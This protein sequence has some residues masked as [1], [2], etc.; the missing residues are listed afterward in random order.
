M[1]PKTRI[2]KLLSGE[3]VDPP[4]MSLWRHFYH[5]EGS[6]KDLAS[7]MVDWQRKWS[8]DF[9]K[10]NP[11]ASYHV[12]GWGAKFT[13]SAE[14]LKKPVQTRFP[15]HGPDDL[16]GLKPL[17]PKERALGEQ[18]AALRL[19]RE[20]LGKDVFMVETVFS[21]LSILADLCESDEAFGKLLREERKVVKLAL[22]FTT[23]MF[24]PF[25]KACLDAGADGIFYATTEWGTKKNIT[26]VEYREFGRPYDLEVLKA[27]KNA[28]FNI[29]HVCKA[30]NLLPSLMD[31]PV[32]AFSWDPTEPTNPGLGE[33]RSKTD[34]VLIGGLDYRK[35]LR[36]PSQEEVRN[37]AEAALSATGGKGFILAAGCTIYPETP[38]ENIRAAEAVR[39]KSQF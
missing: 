11:R 35:T 21:P 3:S 29:L 31:Y 30:D 1:T 22:E 33:V 38:E 26:D 36:G 10:V 8:W 27:V 23:E 9:V 14:E 6:A 20:A 12:E 16:L 17:S 18:L 34:K 2:R 32:Q 7:A 28:E 39:R 5:R 37:Q 4:A 25:A 13:A 19:I 15:V 24:K